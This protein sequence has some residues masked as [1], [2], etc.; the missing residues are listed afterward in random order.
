[1]TECFN[2]WC[3]GMEFNIFWKLDLNLRSQM[4]LRPC[5]IHERYMIAV[6]L[7]QLKVLFGFGLINF[8]ILDLNKLWLFRFRM[9]ESSFFHSA[10]TDGKKEFLKNFCLILNWG[11][12]YKFLVLWPKLLLGIILKDSKEASL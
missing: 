1:M 3:T 6:G 2:I 5:V 10:I 9:S 7:W 11:M 8:K 4:W 12:L